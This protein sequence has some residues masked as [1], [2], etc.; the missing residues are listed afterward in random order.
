[1]GSVILSIKYFEVQ[2]IVGTFQ[3]LTIW[4][5]N[6]VCLLDKEMFYDIINAPTRWTQTF[7]FQA[8][9]GLGNRRG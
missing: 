5:G 1:M 7:L 8:Y 9:H 3:E 6:E 4:I 2:P